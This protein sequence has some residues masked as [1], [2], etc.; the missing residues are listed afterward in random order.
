MA[1][2]SLTAMGRGVLQRCPRCGTGALYFRYLKVAQTCSASGLALHHHRADDAPPY[3]TIFIVGHLVIPP[4]L[5][6]EQAYQPHLWLHAALWLPLSVL[7]SLLLLPRV[8]GAVVGLQWLN[9]MHGF[10][11]TPRQLLP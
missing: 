7:L 11:A 10:E 8:K 9:G 6:V 3:F 5:W 4:M 2:N 1:W